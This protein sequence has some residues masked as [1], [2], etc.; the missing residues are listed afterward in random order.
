MLVLRAPLGRRPWFSRKQT[1]DVACAAEM[2]WLDYDGRSQSSPVDQM[3]FEWLR[4][5]RML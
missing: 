1:V 3:I 5:G 4:D 2:I